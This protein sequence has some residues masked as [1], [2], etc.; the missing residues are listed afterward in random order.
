MNIKPL[1]FL[2][3]VNDY[4]HKESWFPHIFIVLRT[5]SIIYHYE[6]LRYVGVEH[7][8]SWSSSGQPYPSKPSWGPSICR[9]FQDFV[10]SLPDK[11]TNKYKLHPSLGPIPSYFLPS[12]YNLTFSIPYFVSYLPNFLMSLYNHWN[13]LSL[14]IPFS[15]SHIIIKIIPLHY[16]H[17]I[18]SSFSYYH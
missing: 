17:T 1:H 12:L 7:V 3:H 6:W 9:G 14:S 5:F 2:K 18:T 13:F 11:L 16:P 8:T 15:F 10:W 4:Q